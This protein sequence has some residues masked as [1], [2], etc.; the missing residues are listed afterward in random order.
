M[1]WWL[2]LSAPLFRELHF[3]MI[4]IKKHENLYSLKKKTCYPTLDTHTDTF[5]GSSK[6]KEVFRK[7]FIDSS[8]AFEEIFEGV[9][10]FRIEIVIKSKEDYNGIL[11]SSWYLVSVFGDFIPLWSLPTRLTSWLFRSF[12]HSVNDFSTPWWCRPWLFD[13]NLLNNSS[14]FVRLE[15]NQARDYPSIYQLQLTFHKKPCLPWH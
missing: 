12:L 1:W 11:K 5:I 4:V 14:I 3:F 2:L 9:I 6:Y 15:F 10:F 13:N 8:L 7:C